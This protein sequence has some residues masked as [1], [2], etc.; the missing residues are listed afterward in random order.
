VQ[1][2]E[3]DPKLHENTHRWPQALP[4][5]R[6]FLYFARSLQAEAS[7]TYVG[8]LDTK[9]RKLLFRSFSNVVYA[10]AGYLLFVRDSTLMAQPFDQQHLSVHG[11]VIPIDGGVLENLP[12][13]RAIISVSDNG[14]L[15]YG[16]S[17]NMAKP[18][19]LR[20]LDRAGKPV[21][22][23]GD[24]AI[25]TAPRLSPD[26]RRLAVVVGDPLRATTDIWIYDLVGGGKTRLTFDPSINSQPVWSPDGSH[27]VFY[28]NRK[29]SFPQM[30][31]K[32]ANGAGSDELLLDSFSQD[33][34]D[35]WSPDG[36]FIVFEPNVSVNALWV[37]PLS[38]ERKPF[39]FL[40]GESGTYPTEARFSPDGKWLA[41]VEYG[42]GKR[43]VYIT[44]FPGK[45]GKWQVSAAGGRYPRWRGDGKELFFLAQNDTTLVAVDV[46]LSGDIPRIGKPKEL[47]GVHLVYSPMSPEWGAYDVANDGKR[48]LV[49]SPDQAPTEEPINMIVNWDVELKK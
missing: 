48:F 24:P 16:T 2:T 13:S 45:N 1:L 40:S 49:D 17:G 19:R 36:K 37:L 18:T 44:P 47:F 41:Y 25:Y 39:V 10:A 38:G 9:E 3:L 42:S 4:D 21:G 20:W 6:H 11:D 33:R 12:Y 5:G 8:S 22:I 32:A 15:A 7:S 46:D 26:G 35:D 43:E 14:I 27:I 29:N 23:V 30:Y 28:S 31:Q 34:P